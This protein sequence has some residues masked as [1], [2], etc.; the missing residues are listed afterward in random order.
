MFVSKLLDIDAL[1]V[2]EGR[3]I[4]IKLASKENGEQLVE[5]IILKQD[6]DSMTILTE[7]GIRTITNSKINISHI[8]LFNTNIHPEKRIPLVYSNFLIR[9]DLLTAENPND[10]IQFNIRLKR[11]DINM[12][13]KISKTK[14]GFL[15]KSIDGKIYEMKRSLIESAYERGGD[16]QIMSGLQNTPM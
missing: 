14:D 10:F 9:L 8:V 3:G 15:F 4:S 6:Y 11:D 5:G 1:N 16:Y 2:Q 12:V 7:S 13:A